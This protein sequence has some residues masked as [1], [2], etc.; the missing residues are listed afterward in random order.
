MGI[1]PTSVSEKRP[2]TM[3]AFTAIFEHVSGM[4]KH[5]Y[6]HPDSSLEQLLMLLLKAENVKTQGLPLRVARSEPIGKESH[7]VSPASNASEGEVAV[8]LLR[9]LDSESDAAWKVS[10]ARDVALL[11]A[12]A[13]FQADESSA[14]GVSRLF[15]ACRAFTVEQIVQH[16][17]LGPE[18]FLGVSEEGAV[19]LLDQLSQLERNGPFSPKT[20][21]RR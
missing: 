6:L 21:V 10:V 18:G 5:G 13:T 16:S 14:I 19:D 1:Q 17:M 8:Q 15:A 12:R 4:I 9:L 20:A 11:E 2:W 7:V 3:V